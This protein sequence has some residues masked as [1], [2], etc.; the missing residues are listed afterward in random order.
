MIII[1]ILL[2]AHLEK[3]AHLKKNKI[4]VLTVSID[5]SQDT[6]CNINRNK[7]V[8]NPVAMRAVTINI[9]H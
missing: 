7:L 9:I 1:M 6:V 2:I 5:F 3:V 8:A 4:V